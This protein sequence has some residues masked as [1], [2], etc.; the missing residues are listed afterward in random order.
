MQK[1]NDRLKNELINKNLQISKWEQLNNE[2]FKIISDL[3][4]EINELKSI[5]N[6]YLYFKNINEKLNNELNNKNKII[7]ELKINNLS[8]NNLSDNNKNNLNILSKKI[9][10]QKQLINNYEYKI[11]NYNIVTSNLMKCIAIIEESKKINFP[12]ITKNTYMYN[13]VTKW[14]KNKMKQYLRENNII[15]SNKSIHQLK[16][17]IN[18]LNNNKYERLVDRIVQH[19]NN[20]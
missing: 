10:E 20:I 5:N 1:E 16:Q 9:F 4:K 13:D 6:E 2:N 14:S 7:E 19:K 11:K 12:F 3:R 17:Q 15:I 18:Q 8:N